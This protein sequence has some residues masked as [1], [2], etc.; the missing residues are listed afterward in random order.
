MA[1]RRTGEAEKRKTGGVAPSPRRPVSASPR[2]TAKDPRA[3]A[4]EILERVEGTDAY[5]NLLLDARLQKRGLTGADRALATELVYGVLRWRGKLD[6]I[7]AQVLDRP[8]LALDRPVRQILRLGTYQLCCLSRIPDF[9]AVDEAVRLARR[10]GVGRSA[11]YVNA[12]LRSVARRRGTPEVDSPTDPIEYWGSVGS[13]PRWLVERWVARLGPEEAGQLMAA[14]NTAPPVTVLVNG[15]KARIEDARRGLMQAASEVVTG[16]WVPGAFSVR[17]AG[18]VADLPGFAEGWLI[19]MDEAGA[20]PVLALDPRPGQRVLDACA[21]GGSKSALIAARVGAE[22]EVVALDRSLRAMRRLET[23]IR[24]LDLGA[25]RPHLA[26]ARSAGAEWPGQFPRVLL[27][28]PCTGLGTIRR[29]PEIRWRRRPED[30]ASAAALQREL[31]KG[32]AGAVAKDGLLVYSTCSLEPEETD[33]VVA[34]FL[35]ARPEFVLDDPAPILAQP[36]DLVDGEGLL[37]AWPHRDGTDGFF[38]ARFRRQR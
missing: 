6:W 13:H 24:R 12:V 38:V 21:G 11:G 15:L 16:R 20:L 32:V 30:L 4:L 33:A 37:R 14:N 18:G 23:A 7:L 36:A 8:L 10:A 17:G 35:A 5:A 1:N 19:P 28:A 25:V 31:L 26:D 34:A 27:D 22:G 3:L 29:R 2:A 9:A